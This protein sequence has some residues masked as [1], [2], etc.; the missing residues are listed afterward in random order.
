MKEIL[1]LTVGVFVGALLMGFFFSSTPTA[2]AG[3]SDYKMKTL[4]NKVKKLEEATRRLKEDLK[5]ME[6]VWETHKKNY[7]RD[8]KEQ[9]RDYEKFK[10]EFKEHRHYLKM[11]ARSGSWQDDRYRPFE[12]EKKELEVGI[13]RK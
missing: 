6:K 3:S 5:K 1:G 8:S 11:R 9:K 2:L 10:K 7:E 12:I 4:E 13:L